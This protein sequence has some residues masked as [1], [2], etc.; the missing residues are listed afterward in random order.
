VTRAY[1]ERIDRDLA[2]EA[3]TRLV[4]ATQAGSDSGPLEVPVVELAAF[5]ETGANSRIDRN[6]RTSLG[7]GSLGPECK[8]ACDYN[9][10]TAK[11]FHNVVDW[12]KP[13]ALAKLQRNI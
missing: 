2:E 1:R 11:C 9:D 10:N 8:S 13:N 6:C 7:N 12:V 3:E 4:G 5:A